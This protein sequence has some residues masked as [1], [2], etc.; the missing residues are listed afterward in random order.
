MRSK[1]TP[2]VVAT[3]RTPSSA[4]SPAAG[5]RGRGYGPVS[6]TSSSGAARRVP[7][8]SPDH[9]VSQLDSTAPGTTVP[10]EGKREDACRGAHDRGERA[11]QGEAEDVLEA[12][13]VGV[14]LRAAT[15]EE[16]AHQGAGRAARRD[17][18]RRPDRYRGEEGREQRTGVDARPVPRPES[19]EQPQP[20]PGGGPERRD[21]LPW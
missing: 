13:Q 4:A 3:S 12:L 8:K 19:P 2:Q 9:Q 10:A 7:R 1:Y 6:Q 21:V 18:P 17:E 5:Q 20:H 15:E 14:E 16:D 11:D